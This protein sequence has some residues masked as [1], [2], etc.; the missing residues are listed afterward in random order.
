MVFQQ[1]I[2]KMTLHPKRLFLIDGLGALLSAFLLGVVLVKL[3]NIF[4]IPA[5]AL[6]ILAFLPCIFAI[7]DFYCYLSV[8]KNQRYFLTAIALMNLIYCFI[9]IG[10]ALQ[11]LQK[12]TVFGWGYILIEIL[13]LIALITIELKTASKL[14]SK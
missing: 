5:T 1:I 7:Y 10:I 3:E 4:G 8:K 9:S 13:I 11:H 2:D 6:Y 12:I 14:T